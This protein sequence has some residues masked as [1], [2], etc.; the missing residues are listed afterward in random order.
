MASFLNDLRAATI[1]VIRAAKL[2]S[3]LADMR[4]R[5]ADTEPA[6][7]F[8]AAVVG[9]GGPALRPRLIAEIKRA[10]PSKGLLRPRFDPPGLARVYEEAG[11][12][13]LSVLTEERFF[14]GSL[15]DLAAARAAVRLPVLRKDFILDAY[16]IY[17]AR[18]HGA[19]AVLLIA[20]LLDDAQLKDFRDLAAELGMAALIEV[21]AAAEAVRALTVGAPLLGI[22]NRDL[23]SFKTDP[24]LTF[25]ILDQIGPRRG[26][27]SESGIAEPAQIER[28]AGAGV[29]AVL[30]GERFMTSAD[31]PETVRLLWGL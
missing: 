19:D 1:E 10:S 15:A 29:D 18:V 17:Q 4:R 25:R 16:Q 12:A 22:N 11:A 31:I 26:V 6:R 28:L 13:A 14:Q 23:V 21:H 3:N 2:R 9:D 27:V 5:C 20:A 24:D 30:I 7:P 8:E